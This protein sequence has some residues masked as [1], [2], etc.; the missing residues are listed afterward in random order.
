LTYV[1]SNGKKIWADISRGKSREETHFCFF[2]LFKEINKANVWVQA[3]WC[4]PLL[5]PLLFR[6][7]LLVMSHRIGSSLKHYY[8]KKK[9]FLT[10]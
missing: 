9:Q 1:W 3:K 5:F 2:F 6:R 4:A 10:N 8:H 7:I